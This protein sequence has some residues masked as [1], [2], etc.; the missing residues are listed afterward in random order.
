M[1]G[2]PFAFKYT[3]FRPKV[4]IFLAVKIF[5][6]LLNFSTFA[7]ASPIFALHDV[8]VIAN[9]TNAASASIFFQIFH[10]KS[11]NYFIYPRYDGLLS[12]IFFIAISIFF[13]KSLIV[14]SAG[15]LAYWYL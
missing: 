11:S 5:F 9:K 6:Y 13:R 1:Y 7:L 2:V 12:S 3:P 8:K 4:K 15:I 14:V 10:F